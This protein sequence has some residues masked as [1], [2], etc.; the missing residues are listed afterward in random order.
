VEGGGVEGRV[1]RVAQS[2]ERDT[3]Y[4]KFKKKISF[5]GKCLLTQINA[6]S[7]NCNFLFYNFLLKEAIVITRLWSQNLTYATGEVDHSLSSQVKQ[8]Q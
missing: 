6:K 3:E 4:S 1:V 7:I 5:C 2:K 8:T